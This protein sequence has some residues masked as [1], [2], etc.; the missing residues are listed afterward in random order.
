[1]SLLFLR[2]LVFPMKPIHPSIHRWGREKL[3]TVANTMRA[4][5]GVKKVEGATP[6]PTTN[7]LL[8]FFFFFFFCF[9]V[10]KM[11]NI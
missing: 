1:M 9:V 2:A 4:V 11:L 8:F 6:P 5:P 7:P 10:E 3:S